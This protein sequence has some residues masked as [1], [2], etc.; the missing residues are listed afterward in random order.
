[1]TGTRM[2][3]RP[4]GAVV[5]IL[6]V[7]AAGSCSRTVISP[8]PITP[9]R[10]TAETENESLTDPPA[11]LGGPE[12]RGVGELVTGRRT[13]TLPKSIDLMNNTE[14][15]AYLNTLEYDMGPANSQLQ[16]AV[17]VHPG[18]SACAPGDSARMF[19][20]PDVGMHKWPASEIPKNGLIVARIINYGPAGNDEKTFGFPART[21]TWWVVD[22]NGSSGLR[23]RYF[24]RT[25]N[26]AA[27]IRY[28]TMVPHPFNHC[29][30]NDAPAGRPAKGKF[31]N[32]AESIADSVVA[33]W[34]RTGTTRTAAASPGSYFHPAAF[35]SVVPTPTH[36]YIKA[37]TD[38]WVTCDM[39]CCSTS[40]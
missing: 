35:R 8:I 15:V 7:A 11:H 5:A 16:D 28:T 17:C 14:L 3:S 37:I 9:L 25:Y 39:G 12:D 10:Y 24:T 2:H 29:R 30:H 31:W 40:P 34:P 18:G 32:C 4:V 36:P 20:E 21:R 27:P 38:T 33:A 26:A 6:L 22:S 13:P 19:I 23:S 1:M